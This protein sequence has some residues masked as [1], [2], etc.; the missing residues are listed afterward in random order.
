LEK[1]VT[2]FKG[3]SENPLTTG[4][5]EEKARELLEPVLGQARTRQLMDAIE[6]LET[7]A[8]VRDLRPLLR[9]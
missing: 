1:R 6:K 9:S 2:T 7:V 3:R 4:E 5:V 8:S